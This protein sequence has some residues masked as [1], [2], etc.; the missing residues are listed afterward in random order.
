MTRLSVIV[1]TKDESADIRACLDSVRWADEIVVVDGGSR[2]DTV[3]ICREYTDKVYIC[4]DWPGFGPQ[5]NR[6]LSCATGE[7]VLSLDADERVSP[8]LRKEIEHAIVSERFVGYEIPRR[9]SYCGRVLRHGGWWPDHV[10]RL[11]KREQGRFWN[12]RV[13]EKVIMR[14]APG[15]LQEPLIHKTFGSL[16]EVLDK[17][18][19]Y[20]SEGARL[21]YEQG[22]RAGLGAALAH[23]L[24]AFI[25]TY[26]LKAGLLDGREGLMLAISNAEGTYYRYLKL[27]Y[28]LDRKERSGPE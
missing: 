28:L 23:G 5:K 12:R 17:I 3:A 19:S 25:R 9:S 11:F 2:D 1:I 20:S 6:A 16:E 24:W 27:A 26:F 4:N 7:W 10:L 21:F 15:R 14:G 18:N 13:H 22:K 8:A